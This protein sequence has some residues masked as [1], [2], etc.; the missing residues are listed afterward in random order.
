MRC[1]IARLIAP[2]AHAFRAIG[3]LLFLASAT[4]AYGQAGAVPGTPLSPATPP[5]LLIFDENGNSFLNGLRQPNAVAAP[6]GG[7]LYL[8][9]NP[10]VPGVVDV[11]GTPD[12]PTTAP[13]GYSDRLIFD[14]F[15]NRVGQLQGLMI[16]QSWID[17]ADLSHDLADAQFQL[18]LS[19][20]VVAEQGVEGNN[21]F[22]WTA[23]QAVYLGISD[24]AVPEPSTLV[25]GAVGLIIWG[26]AALRKGGVAKMTWN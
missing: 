11:K 23:G 18:P 6:Q 15:Q 21:V 7:A 25:L 17:D 22:I 1:T 19:N 20:F 26:F 4:V 2:S 8:L 12:E 10:V 16:F 14:N 3:C 13:F 9:P 5:S 24:G